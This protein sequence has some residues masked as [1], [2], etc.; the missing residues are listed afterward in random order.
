MER[1]QRVYCP[2]LG[3][4]TGVPAGK[5]APAPAARKPEPE[6][7]A[8]E[9]E[10][11]QSPANWN[12]SH[13]MPSVTRCWAQ[14]GSA[15]AIRTPKPRRAQIRFCI[16]G[17]GTRPGAPKDGFATAGPP[18]RPI[19]GRICQT[20]FINLYSLEFTCTDLYWLVLERAEIDPAAG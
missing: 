2:A 6:W 18:S 5:A 16:R 7:F 3:T 9:E 1:T 14:R 20:I 13:S 8:Y 4:P 12:C 17:G 11:V 15:R 19:S 10:T